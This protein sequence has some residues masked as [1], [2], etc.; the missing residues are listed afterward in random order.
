MP[1]KNSSGRIMGGLIL[2]GLGV[3]F[4][5]DQLGRIDFGDLFSD[6]WPV[7]LILL[8]L[9]SL[10]SHGFR[11]TEGGWVLIFLGAFF[12]LLNLE[13][14]GRDIW[15]YWPIILIALGLWILFKASILPSR[16]NLPR[17]TT[18]DLD[19]SSILSGGTRRVD[20]Q[21]FRGGKATC[22]LGGM[23]IDLREARL[24]QDK[25][26]LE[27]TAILG[28]LE[29]WVP[30]DWQVTV[31]GNPILGSIE[32]KHRSTTP[33]PTP[34]TLFVRATAILGGIEIKN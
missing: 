32:D 24:A 1:S 11:N 15:R 22:I 25:A 6:Y 21:S 12:L 14:F 19:A 9:G 13:I 26:T 7:I 23:E 33:A 30:R 28:G 34:Q 31:E 18:D 8:G 10:A 17:V 29:I 4:L 5:L 2:I 3:L 27:V 16:H 20:S